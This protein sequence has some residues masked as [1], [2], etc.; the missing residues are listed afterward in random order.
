MLALTEV[1]FPQLRLHISSD[2]YAAWRSHYCRYKPG[3]NL[4]PNSGSMLMLM[5]Q[6]SLICFQGQTRVEVDPWSERTE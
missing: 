3:I 2:A 4:K 6:S 1:G 5:H